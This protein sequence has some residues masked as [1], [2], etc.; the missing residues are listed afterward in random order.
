MQD[1]NRIP[2]AFRSAI[3]SVLT[4]CDEEEDLNEDVSSIKAMIDKLKV[5]DKTNFG[6]ITKIES[7][8]ISFKSKDIPLT[9]IAFNQRKMGSKDFVLD[10][11]LKI[12][13]ENNISERY[14][15]NKD[16][17]SAAKM[18]DTLSTL[19]SPN[20]AIANK[21]IRDLGTGYKA[22]FA[23]I[24]N[25]IDDASDAFSDIRKD[26]QTD[27]DE[28][29]AQ[30][31]VPQDL[32]DYAQKIGFGTVRAESLYKSWIKR[33][34][35]KQQIKNL[36]TKY[37]DEKYITDDNDITEAAA[38]ELLYSRV[39]KILTGPGKDKRGTLVSS[40]FKNGTVTI[41]VVDDD[42][43]ASKKKNYT[44]LDIKTDIELMP[45]NHAAHI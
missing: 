20:S 24:Q 23:K 29:S 6:I 30:D 21:V 18:L 7:N 16:L 31:K 11:L 4:R 45:I 19:L 25:L 44:D 36:I 27:L 10:R 5:G 3:I 28:A 2:P 17:A 37:N 1:F 38:S 14:V 9:K 15:E 34:L 40:S 42:A 13:N 8:S 12:T 32:L 26:V 39:Y 22:D 41:R 35:T 43:A 33:G